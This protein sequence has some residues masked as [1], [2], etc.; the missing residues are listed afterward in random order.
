MK[1]GVKEIIIDP[2]NN[3]EHYTYGR[4]ECIDAMIDTQGVDAVIDFCK[5]NAFKYLWRHKHKNGLEDLEKAEWYLKKAI[6]L[7]HEHVTRV[8]TSADEVILVP[9]RSKR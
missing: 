8:N 1:M 6:E 3:P 4:V 7:S 9:E 5:C 2:V